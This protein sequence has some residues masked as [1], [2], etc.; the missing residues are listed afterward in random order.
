MDLSK[1][2]L[3]SPV[4]GPE[5]SVSRRSTH[6]RH[7]EEYKR[8]IV[9]EYESLPGGGTE[10]GSMLRR[11][12]L[13]RTQVYEWRK[14]YAM[15][16]P[17]K[18]RPKRTSEQVEIDKLRAKTAK[19]EAELARTKLALEITGKAHALL[20]MLAESADSETEPSK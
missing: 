13:R 6:R 19:L 7:S 12:G 16:E 17:K 20:E 15:S 5:F 3:P 4:E 2:T 18:R 14:T 1:M 11:E 9:D 10:R 8:R